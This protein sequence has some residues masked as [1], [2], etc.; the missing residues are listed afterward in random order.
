MAVDGY[1]NFD[2]KINTDGFNKG[3]AAI[4]K[5]VSGAGKTVSSLG[6]MFTPITAAVTGVGAAAGKTALDFTKL[7][8]STMVVFEKMLGGK[9][10]ANGLYTSLLSIAKASTFSQ[11]AFLTAGKKLVGM[12]INAQDTAK[13]MQAITDAVAGFGGT[14]ENLTNVAENFAKISTAGRLS[15]EDV[16]MLSDNG[17]QALKILGNQYGVATDEMRDMISDGAIPAKEAMDK[18]TDGIEN[19]TDGVNGYTA[20]MKGMSLAMKGKTLIG[21]LDSLNSGFRSFALNLVGINPT[22]KE[23]DEGYEESTKKLQQ[24]TA[25]ISTI[26]NILPKAASLFTGVSDGLGKLLDKIVG[27]NVAFDEATGKWEN[28]GGILGTIQ[29]KLSSMDADSLTKIGNAILGMATAGAVLPIVGGGIGKVGE[30]IGI[31]SKMTGSFS[32]ATNT[33]L[34]SLGSM[35]KAFQGVKKTVVEL[36]KDFK[37]IGNAITI[38]FEGVGDKLSGIFSKV[39]YR[40]GY[41]GVGIQNQISKFVTPLSSKISEL[42]KPFTKLGSLLGKSLGDIGTK[43]FGYA[44]IIGD[45]FTPILKKAAGFA[46]TFLKYMNIAG[47]IGIIAAGLGLLYSQYGEQIDQILLMVQTKGPEI[48]TGFC[49]GITA[50]LPNLIEQG[51]VLI[52]NLM[53]AITANLP[54]L[55]TGGM[56]IV[57]SLITGVSSQLPMLIPIAVDMVLTLVQSLVSNL[58]QLI[59]SGLKLL[60]GFVQGLVNAIPKIVAAVPQI[61]TSLVTT[62]ISKGP[63]ILQTGIQLI[64]QLALGLVRAIPQLVSQIPA[65]IS[66]IKNAFT[67]VDWGSVGMNIIRGIASGI[68]GA[69]GTLIEAAAN[70]AES[71]LNWVKDKLGIK[72]PSRVFRDEV[73]KMM[74]LGMG[75][76]FEK[77]VPLASMNTGVENAIKSIDISSLQIKLNSA[78]S[79]LQNEAIRSASISTVN[80]APL[81]SFMGWKNGQN[82]KP[83][84]IY[85]QTKAAL[86][87]P[88]GR[89]IAE[90]T[91][92][93]VDA[94]IGNITGKKGRYMK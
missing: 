65:I 40:V 70:A 38:P 1:L 89:V 94:N 68:S 82:E 41:L 79:S 33:V 46:P 93:Y 36:G 69:V 87:L 12:G 26:A 53:L 34:G 78:L 30:A 91:T 47:G 72:S 11:E 56:N 61:I 16:N 67:S 17:I 9:E 21:A 18:L 23:T 58:P 6:K 66:A 25:A 62:L 88:D 63:Q 7:Y 27:A 73:G 80:A 28:V 22:L 31:V 59:D 90:V 19:G 57:T 92:P 14:S 13:Y 37:G 20:A 76:G 4:G 10:A 29:D 5:M 54:A 42:A 35:P 32:N 24:L 77:N 74:A 75:L 86:T 84:Q 45:S 55:V 15:M 48:I 43:I 52:N 44:S 60:E 51:A 3:I 64:V 83:Q 81:E 2:T 85:V 8:E 50:A 39:I 49:D 71:A